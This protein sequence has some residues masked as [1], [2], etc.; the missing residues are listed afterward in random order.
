MN[1]RRAARLSFVISALLVSREAWCSDQQAIMVFPNHARLVFSTHVPSALSQKFGPG[2]TRLTFVR[3]DGTQLPLIP[4]ELLTGDGGVIFSTV[5]SHELSHGGRCLVLDLT[6]NGIMENEAGKSV[7]ASREFCP[8]L[9][10][11]NGCVSRDYTGGICGGA[12]DSKSEIWHSQLDSGRPDSQSMN[13]LVKPTAKAIWT[14]Y[15]RA[16]SSDIRPFLRAALG[17]SN[18]NACDPPDAENASYYAH[19]EDALHGKASTATSTLPPVDVGAS[20]SPDASNLPEWTVQSERAWLY[21]R[22]SVG[23][24]RHGY[25][26]RG[27]RVTVLGE[28]DTG[29]MRIRYARADKPPIEAWMQRQDITR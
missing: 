22:P 26:I 23:S 2:W 1:M 15:S 21:E 14:Q 4:D 18:I 3:P 11:V 19:I 13:T 24:I 5:G 8:I 12:W 16:K 6:R 9:D 7:A 29:W 28:Q 20:P 25:L 17:L 10:T 27:D